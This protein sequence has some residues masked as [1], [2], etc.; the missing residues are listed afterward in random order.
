MTCNMT[1]YDYLYLCGACAALFPSDPHKSLDIYV[2]PIS[3]HP[4]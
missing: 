3:M 4:T 1:T 2:Y